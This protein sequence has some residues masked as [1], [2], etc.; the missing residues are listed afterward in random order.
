MLAKSPRI[1]QESA[2]PHS[3]II[4]ADGPEAFVRVGGVALL[5]RLLRTL[6]RCG[7]DRAIILSNTPERVRN[8]LA[9]PAPFRSEIAIEIH[10]RENGPVTVG[11]I[12]EVWPHHAG[13]MLVLRGE[14]AFASRLVQW[15]DEQE[16]TT[17][18]VDSDP[19]DDLE[20]LVASAPTTT[21]GQICGITLL[22]RNWIRSRRG[23]FEELVREE[24]ENGR[25][26]V[27]DIATRTWHFTSM[28][29]ELRPYWFAAPAPAQ[30]KTA[31]RVLLDSAQK[32]T[33]DLPA[34]VHAPIEDWLVSRLCKTRITP[35]QLTFLTN[36]AAWCATFLFATGRLGWGVLCA[37]AVGVLDGLDG[38]QARVKMETSRGGELE[39]WFDAFFEN[40]W[41]IAFAFFLFVSGQ[42][43]SA[44]AWLLLMLAAEGLAGLTKWASLQRLG[45]SVYELGD[46]DRFLRLIGAR[47]NVHVWILAAGVLLGNPAR[48]FVMAA[49]W[50]A[51]TSVMQT[52]RALWM[53][54]KQRFTEA[55]SF[56]TSPPALEPCTGLTGVDQSETS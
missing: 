12:A 34:I 42:L 11:A 46:F 43:P 23:V 38:K 9:G 30:Q 19:P 52:V 27:A 35:N 7:M 33:L 10:E 20:A 24:V 41:W 45:V 51:I 17:T 50:E 49:S 36:A 53:M 14:R 6:Q 25:I 31:M 28:R 39:H 15:I 13:K 32:G 22:T 1:V 40:S 18:L 56:L 37:L 4:L 54:A 26:E 16:Q 21:R 29:R 44:F 48:A 3:C 2:V 55:P 8:G 47:R 5:D